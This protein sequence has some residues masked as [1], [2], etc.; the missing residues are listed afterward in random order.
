MTEPV[1]ARR[2][3]DEEG[4]RLQRPGTLRIPGRTC[5]TRGRADAGG[6]HRPEGGS[7]DQQL[8]ERPPAAWPPA[9]GVGIRGWSGAHRTMFWSH[10]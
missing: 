3:S 9:T 10:P 2:L 6:V 8:P 1:R 4:R 5:W 7:D